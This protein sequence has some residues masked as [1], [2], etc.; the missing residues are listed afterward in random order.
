MDLVR[1]DYDEDKYILYNK[2][3]SDNVNQIAK[4]IIDKIWFN[5]T[6]E[7]KTD[8]VKDKR[9]GGVFKFNFNDS[10]Y[11]VKYYNHTET[12]KL[13][14]NIFRKP[15][16]MRYYMIAKQLQDIGLEAPVP[17]IVG[18]RKRNL[19]IEDSFLVTEK[20]PGPPIREYLWENQLT[21]DERVSIAKNIGEMMARLLNNNLIHLDPKLSNINIDINNNF[22]TILVDIDGI[23]KYP[24]LPKAIEYQ[25]IARLYA[26]S[27]NTKNIKIRA[28][29]KRV[30][31]KSFLDDYNREVD[32]NEFVDVINKLT[33]KRLKKNGKGYL[34]E[35]MN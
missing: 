23:Y 33:I 30:F 19:L 26:Y 4:N 34:I 2:N 25:N 29:E 22:S 13:L 35:K 8:L 27:L 3:Y 11:Y 10:T 1:E 18:I 7:F 5:K 9:K 20:V 24:F 28:I 17:I 21:E 31:V 16:A 15:D 32:Y 12:M 14:K 6:S